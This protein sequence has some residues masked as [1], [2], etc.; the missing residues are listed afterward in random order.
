M[1]PPSTICRNTGNGLPLNNFKDGVNKMRGDNKTAFWLLTPL[2]TGVLLLFGIPLILLLISSMTF[3]VGSA[4]FAGLS[5]YAS[6]MR[7]VIFQLALKNTVLFTISGVCLN[8]TLSF[9]IALML[10]KAFFSSRILRSVILFPMFLPVSAV[11][12]IFTLLFS[13]TG[14]VNAVLQTW[15]MPL[16]DWLRGDSAFLV[17]LG[18]YIMKSFGF[19]V[20][21]FLAGLGMIPNELYELAE[22][23]GANAIHKVFH[24][25]LPMLSQTLFFVAII[26]VVNCMKSF[27]EILVLGGERPAKS[28]YML[29][30][31]INNNM[32]NLNYQRLS[33]ATILVILLF[34][35]LA[36]ILYRLE[37]RMEERLKC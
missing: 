6:V 8:M 32:K 15:G 19:N 20:V 21:L 23:E 10:K 28:I 14:A 34:V 1:T 3:G 16:S 2:L 7:S 29:S 11:V 30:H 36:G 17:M 24:I 27:R 35:L 12:I 25:T 18:I 4:S 31:F 26:S 5:N 37:R 13:E 22:I 9:L 33:A